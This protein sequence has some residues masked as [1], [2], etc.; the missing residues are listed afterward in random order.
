M[1]KSK[2]HRATVT[3][4]SVDYDG[5]ITIDKGLMAAADIFEYEQ[6]HV[7]DVTNGHRLVTYAICGAPGEI[8]VN[9]AAARLVDVGD[10]IIIASYGGLVPKE[11]PGCRPTIVLL[12]GQNRI[13]KQKSSSDTAATD[14]DGWI[15]EID[16]RD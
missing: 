9:G 15:T 11:W 2:I 13:V 1:L 4:A 5:S 6:V 16:P 12:D 14:G 7:L 3:G 10:I 8:C